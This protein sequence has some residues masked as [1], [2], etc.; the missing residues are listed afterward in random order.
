[1]CIRCQLSTNTTHF[2]PEKNLLIFSICSKAL[3]IW[4]KKGM[5]TYTQ[6]CYAS[7][8]SIFKNWE[9]MSRYNGG[10]TLEGSDSQREPL[11]SE[12]FQFFY[13][14]VFWQH[15]LWHL[16]GRRTGFAI[17]QHWVPVY[18]W[19]GHV[20]HTVR[21]APNAPWR[22]NTQRWVL[23]AGLNSPKQHRCCNFLEILSKVV[24]WSLVE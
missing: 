6:E 8:V 10:I 13:F 3:G 11:K 20:T 14:T 24:H 1:M 22:K 17:L 15:F 5:L 16:W 21:K 2:F 7:L 12:F 23:W 4:R 18:Q 19:I 9:K